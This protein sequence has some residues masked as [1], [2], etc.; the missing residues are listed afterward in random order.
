[1]EDFFFNEPK[2]GYNDNTL[3]CSRGGDFTALSVLTAEV[4]GPRWANG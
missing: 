4:S 2:P 3:F 1:M